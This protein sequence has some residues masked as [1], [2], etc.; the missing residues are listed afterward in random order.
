METGKLGMEK[1]KRK[2]SK[3]GREPTAS[4]RVGDVEKKKRS[5]KR[6]GRVSKVGRKIGIQKE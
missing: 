6:D 2:G 5:G 4:V 3:R 1:S